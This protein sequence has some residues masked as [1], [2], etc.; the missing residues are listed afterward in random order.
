MNGVL[1]NRL[2]EVARRYIST[3]RT[4]QS[5]EVQTAPKKF[6][7]AWLK[8]KDNQKDFNSPQNAHINVSIYFSTYIYYNCREICKKSA[9]TEYLLGTCRSKFI[10]NV[11]SWI[12][13]VPTKLV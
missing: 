11:K 6:A 1:R 4:L 10:S 3:A 9:L 12:C 8:M 2:G 13:Q 5:E 7:P